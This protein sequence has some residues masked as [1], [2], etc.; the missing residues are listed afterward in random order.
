[1]AN[2]IKLNNEK[3]KMNS[4][5]DGKT[6]CPDSATCCQLTNGEYAC[7]PMVNAICCDDHIHCCPDGYTCDIKDSR[8]NK[9]GEYLPFG[10]KFPTTKLVDENKQTRISETQTKPVTIKPTVSTLTSVVCP[11]GSSFC[12]NDY[13]CCLNED[14]T[15]GCCPM[16]KATCCSDHLHCCP[17]NTKCDIEKGV[18]EHDES[19]EQS[20]YIT[21]WKQKQS[22]HKIK[23]K[24]M[25]NSTEGSVKADPVVCKDNS[26]CDP[27]TVCCLMS[28]G[29]YGC[30]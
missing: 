25:F 29:A 18:C 19:S 15:Y 17:E 1:M 24:K 22:A 23:N 9:N 6:A 4:C 16:P 2:K 3:E 7:C 20:H 5:P 10:V 30:W 28:N 26:T 13:T 11:D 21:T 12:P 8:C 27:L 14:K